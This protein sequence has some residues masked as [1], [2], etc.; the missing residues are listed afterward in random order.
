MESSQSGACSVHLLSPGS[1]LSGL[2][3]QVIPSKHRHRMAPA[4]F[5]YA[6]RVYLGLPLPGGASLA[7]NRCDECLMVVDTL[8]SHWLSTCPSSRAAFTRRH[9]AV[10]HAICTALL[11][12]GYTSTLEPSLL[13]PN[14]QGGNPGLRA[15]QLVYGL[16]G[17]P[18]AFVDVAITCPT[19]PTLLAGTQFRRGKAARTK[20]QQKYRKYA[21]AV[22]TQPGGIELQPNLCH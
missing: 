3:L 11:G 22:R 19:A 7:T 4:V 10:N 18:E 9:T 13:D 21:T 14:P 2:W 12:T 5:R 6:L 1:Q 20:F 17:Q 16:E 15:D 8:G